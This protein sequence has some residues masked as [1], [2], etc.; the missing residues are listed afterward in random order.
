MAPLNDANTSLVWLVEPVI[1]TAPTITY[2]AV[3][4][5]VLSGVMEPPAVIGFYR[6]CCRCRSIEQSDGWE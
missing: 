3:T 2:A 5:N 1:P 6:E 4:A